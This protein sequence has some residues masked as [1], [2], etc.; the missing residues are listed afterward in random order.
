MTNKRP[1]HSYADTLILTLEWMG[2]VIALD[3]GIALEGSKDEPFEAALKKALSALNKGDLEI[4]ES[5]T[6][7]A[8]ERFAEIQ[9]QVYQDR[10]RNE[11]PYG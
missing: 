2:G 4:A 10:R 11:M 1:A 9:N 3:K 7:L 6:E 8:V 5:A